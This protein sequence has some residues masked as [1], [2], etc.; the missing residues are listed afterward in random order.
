MTAQLHLVRSRRALAIAA[1]VSTLLAVL[2]QAA[3]AFA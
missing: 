3:P 2:M 1:A